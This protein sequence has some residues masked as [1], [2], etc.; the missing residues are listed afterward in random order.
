MSDQLKA[1]AARRAVEYVREG[2][3]VGLGTGSTA[4]FAI[5]ALGDRVSGGLTIICV[6]TSESSDRLGRGLGLQ[7]E[8]VED[9]P[10]IDLTIDGA[11]EVDGN[12]DLIKGLGGALLRE[13]I[14][15]AATAEEIII[16]DPSKL[17]DRLGTRG[18][19]PV[20]VVPFGWPL[21]Q[22]RLQAMGATA[23]LR[24]LP[25]SDTPFGTD[26][27]NYILDCTF[28]GGLDNAGECERRIDEVPGVVE[29]GLFIG[30]TRRVVVGQPDGT[31]QVLERD[32][33]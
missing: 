1:L 31:C 27:G 29:S 19:L 28:P 2:M 15:A 13:K 7:V 10:S 3:V 9:H 23:C 26:N 4:E 8:P 25:A 21:T 32:P 12:L 33:I 24:R 20:E 22:R 11:D 18:P 16:V 17:V 14:V 6:A 30:L 5:R